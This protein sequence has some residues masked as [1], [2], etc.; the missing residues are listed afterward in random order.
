[1]IKSISMIEAHKRTYVHYTH[2]EVS[3]PWLAWDVNEAHWTVNIFVK[4]LDLCF[5]RLAATAGTAHSL[6]SCQNPVDLP[7]TKKLLKQKVSIASHAYGIDFYSSWAL[8]SNHECRDCHVHWSLIK[9]IIRSYH[10]LPAISILIERA[11]L[12]NA[13]LAS[14]HFDASCTKEPRLKKS[15][16]TWKTTLRDRHGPCWGSQTW[17]F[18]PETSGLSKNMSH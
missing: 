8:W 18:C 4:E 10:G 7:K 2:T 6:N 17:H 11:T 3:V 9:G 15:Q 12:M 13:M 5:W 1:M 16:D 14:A